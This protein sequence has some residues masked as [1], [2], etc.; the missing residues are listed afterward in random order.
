M[1]RFLIPLAILI[2]LVI[3]AGVAFVLLQHPQSTTSGGSQGSGNMFPNSGA[4]SQGSTGSNPSGTNTSQGSGVSTVENTMGGTLVTKDFLNNGVTATSPDAEGD[5]Y[6][7]GDPG[8]C[9]TSG[10]A[11]KSSS[12][13][14]YVVYR[15]SAKAFVI[16]LTKEPI[17]QSRQ[18]AEQFLMNTLGITQTQ[19][20]DLNYFVLTTVDVN[21][22]YSGKNL[23]FS[24]CPGAV[25][26]PQ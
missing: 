20:C 18:E 16:G 6:L 17:G 11:A 22:N 23:G 14:Y 25:T 24:F 21:S 3:I 19:M 15:P 10:C 7:A 26:L 2:L 1:K 4:A 9:P 5:Y 13:D 12:P 8:F